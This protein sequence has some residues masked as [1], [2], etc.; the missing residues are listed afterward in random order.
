MS[1]IGR[2]SEIVIVSEPYKDKIIAQILKKI[3]NKIMLQYIK[4]FFLA[5]AFEYSIALFFLIYLLSYNHLGLPSP[6]ELWILGEKMFNQYG[7]WLLI[8]GIMIEG[9]FMLG[10]YFPGSIIILGSIILLAKTPTDVFL[11]ILIG[12]IGLVLVNIINYLLG[13][14]GYYKIFNALGAQKTLDRMEHRFRNNRK[15]VIFVFASSPNFLAIASI[16]A[17]IARTTLKKYIPFMALSV[18]FWVSL[19]SAVLFIFFKDITITDNSNLGWYGFT[20]TLLWAFFE[21]S[22]SIYKDYTNKKT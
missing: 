14:Y 17:G 22:L 20:I 8:F 3:Y 16:Y 15:S 21:S 5:A 18:I 9:L 1:H 10:F 2:W 4:K 7:F 19:V 13:R 12:S 11:V 6:G